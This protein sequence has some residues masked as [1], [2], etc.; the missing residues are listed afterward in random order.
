MLQPSMYGSDVNY[1]PVM[2]V[3][4]RLGLGM[5]LVATI[6]CLYSL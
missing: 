3:R 2:M 6:T 5:C 1:T 4:V